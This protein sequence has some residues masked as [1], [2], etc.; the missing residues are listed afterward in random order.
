MV[1]AESGIN[2]EQDLF[3]RPTYSVICFLFGT[4]TIEVARVVLILCGLNI[5]TLLYNCICILAYL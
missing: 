2:S 1:L 3:M 4:E 5:C